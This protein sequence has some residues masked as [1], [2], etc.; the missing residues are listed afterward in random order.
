MNVLDHLFEYDPQTHLKF[1]YDMV[2]LSVTKVQEVGNLKEALDI[3]L[4]N[5]SQHKGIQGIASLPN[6]EKRQREAT[7]RGKNLEQPKKEKKD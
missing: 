3:Y 2:L 7:T 1:I 5:F 6:R 4:A